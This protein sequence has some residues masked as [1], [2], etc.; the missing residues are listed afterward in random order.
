MTF[1]RILFHTKIWFNVLGSFF[2]FSILMQT[3]RIEV[4]SFL[5]SSPQCF[6]PD[7]FNYY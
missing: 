5:G 2:T 6:S 4:P 1:L 3:L 7:R